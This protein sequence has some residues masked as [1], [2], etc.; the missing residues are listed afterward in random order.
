MHLVV[1]SGPSTTSLIKP[2]SV[3]DSWSGL[4]LA[5]GFETLLTF[6]LGIVCLA[7]HALASVRGPVAFEARCIIFVLLMAL[8]EFLPHWCTSTG[9]VVDTE[10]VLRSLDTHGHIAALL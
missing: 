4:F 1:R 2:F 8:L 7:G 6:F 5:Q 3:L 9:P 10:S